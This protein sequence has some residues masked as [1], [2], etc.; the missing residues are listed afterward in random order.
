MVFNRFETQK[1]IWISE[2]MIM[3]IHTAEPFISEPSPLEV[4]IATAKLKKLHIH[5]HIHLHVVVLN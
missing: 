2:V 3:E 1:N 4:E 5:F